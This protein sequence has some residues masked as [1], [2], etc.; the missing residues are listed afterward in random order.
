M[1]AVMERK[2]CLQN[3]FLH[4]SNI[5]SFDQE[6]FDDLFIVLCSTENLHWI[7]DF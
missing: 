5:Y 3:N 2:R 6:K 4:G 7:T 1:A